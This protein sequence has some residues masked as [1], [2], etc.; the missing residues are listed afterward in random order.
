M[1]V[2]NHVLPKH[3]QPLHSYDY[4][5]LSDNSF[6]VRHASEDEEFV[7]LDGDE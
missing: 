6:G 3:S 4:D 7:T 1:G 5:Q 2:I